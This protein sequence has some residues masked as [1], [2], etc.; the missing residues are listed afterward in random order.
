MVGPKMSFWSGKRVFITGHTGFKGA[1]LTE[2]LVKMGAKVTGYSLPAPTE[3]NLFTQLGLA[4]KITHIEADITDRV[5]MAAEIKKAQ[6]EILFHMAAQSLV[7]YSYK[8][9]LE[10]FDTNFTGTLNVL[11]AARQAGGIK[12]LVVITTD[13]CYLN[14]DS[15]KFFEEDDALGGKDPYSASKAAAEI[16][17]TAYYQSF[18]KEAGVPT[19]SARAGNVIGGGDWA[20]DR[21]IPDVIRAFQK[22]K[23]VQIRSPKATRPWQ[24]VLEPLGGYMLLAERLYND[25][26]KFA[27]GWNFGPKEADI[28]PV[29]YVLEKLKTILPF[30]LELDRTPQPVEAKTL[31]LSIKK[32]AKELDWEPKLKL[33][34]AISWTGNWY[35]DFID[36]KDI[37]ATTDTQIKEYFGL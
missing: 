15:G 14:N 20:E 32:A 27:G 1:W 30:K 26:H 21:L 12:A 28:Q 23:P 7:R 35:K 18:L 25:G 5:R 4:K 10:T 31:A 2:T 22:G 16:V 9:P 6:P 33:D 8:N 24:L 13:K 29:E 11:E 36:G 19:A 17:T 37:A 34:D 3:P